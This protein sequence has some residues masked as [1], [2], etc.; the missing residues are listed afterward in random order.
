M[1]VILASEQRCHGRGTSVHIY[2]RIVLHGH[3]EHGF[4]TVAVQG[5]LHC[6]IIRTQDVHRHDLIE[7]EVIATARWIV[8]R[9]ILQGNRHRLVGKHNSTRWVRG[10]IEMRGRQRVPAGVGLA[11]VEHD[12]KRNECGMAVHGHW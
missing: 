6:D 11:A 4:I 2:L 10:W 9:I 5:T 1:A 8:V 12:R 3:D 7:H